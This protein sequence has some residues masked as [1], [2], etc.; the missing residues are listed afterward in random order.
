MSTITKLPQ[1]E[2]HYCTACRGLDLA[3]FR[4][5]QGGAL[6]PLCRSHAVMFVGEARVAALLAPVQPMQVAA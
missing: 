5:Q 2:T 4:C 3:E 6:A 1:T